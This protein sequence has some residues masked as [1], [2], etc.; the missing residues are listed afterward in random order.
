MCDNCPLDDGILCIEVFPFIYFSWRDSPCTS[1]S[2][3]CD[4]Y[5]TYSLGYWP[6]GLEHSSLLWYSRVPVCLLHVFLSANGL[7]GLVIC[8]A[9][10]VVRSVN[11]WINQAS[12]SYCRKANGHRWVK[13]RSWQLGRRRSYERLLH[14]FLKVWRVDVICGKWYWKGDLNLIVWCSDSCIPP[15]WYLMNG[16]IKRCSPPIQCYCSL[17]C[18]LGLG[19]RFKAL[20]SLEG[21]VCLRSFVD[22]RHLL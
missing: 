20:V 1:S 7:N 12:S 8:W 3:H 15:V 18:G 4:G 2:T 16:L 14:S 9:L 11:C 19:Q 21:I 17:T 10:L 13:Q 6:H 5:W 22:T